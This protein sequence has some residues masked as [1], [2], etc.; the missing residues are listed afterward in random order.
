MAYRQFDRRQ[1]LAGAAATT[2][3]YSIARV[4]GSLAQDDMAG[5]SVTIR[6]HDFSFEVPE[7]VP[8]GYTEITMINE[9]VEDHHAQIVR[10][11]DGV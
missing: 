3:A 6:A 10:L 9:G 4:G 7:E 8:A 2:A 11:N 5:L 1:L